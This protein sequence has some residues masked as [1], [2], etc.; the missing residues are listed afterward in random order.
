MTGVF[1][2]K[3]PEIVH[4]QDSAGQDVAQKDEKEEESLKIDYD[5]YA[6]LRL[7]P[8]RNSQGGIL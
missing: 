6:D 1:E 7:A 3:Q 2:E 8:P 4:V 5:P